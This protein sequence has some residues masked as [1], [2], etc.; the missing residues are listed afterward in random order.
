MKRLLF[1]FTFA[2][3]GIYGLRGQTADTIRVATPVLSTDPEFSTGNKL[4]VGKDK[5]TGLP[6]KQGNQQD[7]LGYDALDALYPRQQEYMEVNQLFKPKKP[8]KNIFNSSYSRYVLPAAF[9]AYGVATR[10]SKDLRELDEST[11][12]EVSEHL[13]SK[14]P[15]DD[16]L[17]FAPA[18]AVYAL[19][20]AG[21]AKAKHN[22][23]DRTIIMATSHIIM[24]ATVQTMKQ[25]MHIE[26]PDGS[27]KTSFPSGHTATAFVG[28]HILCREYDNVP[29]AI[30]GYAMAT[31]TGVLRVLNKKHWVS[32]VIT[33]A[34][35]GILSA[36]AGYLL[37]PAM[38]KL[39]HIKDEK[40]SLVV[41][42]V[43][44]G[45]SYGVG[46]AYR[47]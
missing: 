43:F 44:D 17:Q 11:H 22:F 42:P 32:D 20:M 3:I 4:V 30:G 33:G 38:K 23:R 26:R 39:F 15:V 13:Y 5:Q 12:N 35:I 45:K 29:I 46:L 25:T 37:L 31:A 1:I 9:I 10:V 14:I 19:D 36:E 7:Y 47:F 16:Y 2:V 21:I 40:R 28:A 8:R 18:V 41:A 6:E 34:G 24:G 27:S